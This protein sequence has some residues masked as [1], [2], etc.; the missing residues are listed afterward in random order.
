MRVPLP[1]AMIT[2]STGIAGNM[3]RLFIMRTSVTHPCLSC[4]IIG[5]LLRLLA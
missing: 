4:R 2:T 1:A 3:S 5:G